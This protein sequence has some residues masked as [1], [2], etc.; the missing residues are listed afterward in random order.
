MLTYFSEKNFTFQIHFERN[1]SMNRITDVVKSLI[2]INVIMFLGTA[3]LPDETRSMLALYF[4][5]SNSFQ[6]F[7]IVTHMF[8]HAGGSLFHIAFNMY[9]LFLFGSALENLWGSKRFLFYYLFCGFGAA[10]F[11]LLIKYIEFQS[12]ANLVP[13]HVVQEIINGATQIS[14]EY[15]FA[16][17]QQIFSIVHTPMLGASGAVFGLLAGYGMKFP[18]NKLGVFPLP[19]FIKAKYFVLIYG[20][21]EL[22]LGM[23]SYNTGIAHFAHLGGAIFGFF[24]IMYWNKFGSRL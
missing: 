12:A 7:Q 20:A 15:D 11:Y 24:L 16:T 19:F 13:S 8:M 18:N 4:P 22:S 9:A 17:L 3:M 6:P 2:I 1:I 21:I 14:G 10:G 5:K 23:S